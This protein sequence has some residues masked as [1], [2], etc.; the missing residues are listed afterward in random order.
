M[1]TARTS[2]NQL[3]ALVKDQGLSVE[4]VGDATAPRGTYEAVYEGHR[5]ARK[6]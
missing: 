4:M 1:V 3:Y 5:Q 2:E 6:V